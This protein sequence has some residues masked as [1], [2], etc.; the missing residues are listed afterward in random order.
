MTTII[1]G[2]K[3]S[4]HI[5][6]RIKKEVTS[7][8]FQPIFCDVLVGDDPASIQYVRMKMRMAESVGIK[9]HNASFPSSI[10]TDGLIGEIKKINNIPNICG[11]IVQLPLPESLDRRKILD[12]IDPDLDVDCLGTV[13]SEKF[14]NNKMDLGFP[15]ALACMLLLDSLDLDLKG[16]KIV[17]LG[18]GELMGKPVSALLSFRG[19]SP[20]II[21]SKTKNKEKFIKEA[22][23]IISGMGNGKYITG[24][25]IKEGSVII[26]AGTSEIGN[27]SADGGVKIV[28]DVDLESVKGVAS[29]VSPVPGGVGPVT[30]AML[31]NNVLKVARKKMNP[32]RNL[33]YV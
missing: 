33:I 18:Q 19:F 32:D 30:V 3:I 31:F 27:G 7:L 1:D 23:V 4:N 25:M 20:T 29:F 24:S 13:A 22:D 15:T 5:L 17:V 8:G 21:T 11:I 26:D 16:K 6:N 10:S 28:G 12:A 14:Y 2:K 9:F